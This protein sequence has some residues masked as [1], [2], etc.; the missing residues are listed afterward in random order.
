MKPFV[1]RQRVCSEQS[2]QSFLAFSF[3]SISNCKN[4]SGRENVLKKGLEKKT[5]QK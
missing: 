3:A 1:C 4:A 5:S 2:L